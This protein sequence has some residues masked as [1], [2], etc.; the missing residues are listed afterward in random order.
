VLTVTLAAGVLAL[1]ACGSSETRVQVVPAPRLPHATGASL[2]ARSDAL[3]AAL[4][5]RD[6][7]GARIQVHGLEKQ[8]RLEI[9][10]GRVPVV[11]RKRLLAAVTQLAAR[12]PRCVPPPPPSPPPPPA[13]PKHKP[14]KHDDHKHH[15]KKGKDH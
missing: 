5:R 14:K 8:T 4:R 11:Y 13:P 2:A 6:A 12:V 1:G 3:A 10:S 9:A 7:C 15:G